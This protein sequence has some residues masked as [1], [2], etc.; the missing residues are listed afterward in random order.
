MSSEIVFEVRD[1]V[2]LIRLNRPEKLN[3]FTN[4]MLEDWLEALDE[5]EAREGVRCVVITGTGRG[6]TTGGDV[7]TMGGGRDNS[8]RATKDRIWETIQAVP[9]RLAAMDTPTIAAVNGVATGGGVDVALA[10]DIRV[11]AASARFAETYAR[12][13]L[14]PGAGGAYFLPRAVG[15]ARALEL[16][17]TAEFIDAETAERIGLVNHV[18]PDESFLDDAMALAGRIAAAAP[19]SVR[20]I[21]RTVYR[22]LATDMLTSFDLVSS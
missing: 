17:W 11:C 6:F 18:Y 21:K 16:L 15:T 9:K 8:P 1:K 7:S 14:I 10:C 3:A 13:G 22:S 12:L 20:Y 19:L 2:G 5:A 4:V